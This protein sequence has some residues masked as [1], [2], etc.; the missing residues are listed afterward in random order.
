MKRYIRAMSKGKS[1]LGDYFE[2]HTR[3]IIY[4][5]IKLYLYP[6]NPAVKHWR[7]E[8]ANQLSASY[9]LRGSHKLP[10]ADFIM[11]NSFDV[12]GR[13]IPTSIKCVIDQ[14]GEPEYYTHD[15]FDAQDLA[16]AESIEQY[17]LWLASRLSEVQQIPYSEIYNYLENHGF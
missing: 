11:K 8:V 6:S 7:R 12:H 2:T 1:E 13:F 14:Y 15:D 10:S 9:T 5:L 3:P 16:L 17:F 4:H